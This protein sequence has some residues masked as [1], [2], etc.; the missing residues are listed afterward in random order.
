MNLK[1]FEDEEKPQPTSWAELL[2]VLVELDLTGWI[3]RG[4]GNYTYKPVSSLERTLQNSDVDLADW[5]E[6]ENRALAFFKE[7]AIHHRSETPADNDLVGWW[8]LM[9]HYGAPTRL[10][11]WTVSP[12]VACYFAYERSVQKAGSAA[13][14]MLNVDECRA[15]F[16][17]LFLSGRRDHMGTVAS[18]VH[19]DGEEIE[20]T[21]PG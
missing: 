15:P 17:E 4:L 7:R 21:Y 3:F 14:W 20:R 5:R 19:K 6:R 2:Q 13:L 18:S 9:Q 8:A 10:T 16:G 1:S 12:F 11:D